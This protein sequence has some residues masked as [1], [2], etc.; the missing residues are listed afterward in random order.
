[1]SSQNK[2]KGLL[3]IKVLF[4]PATTNVLTYFTGSKI[5]DTFKGKNNLQEIKEVVILRPER[6]QVLRQIE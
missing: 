6:E 5:K 2:K 1:V 4:A 3:G